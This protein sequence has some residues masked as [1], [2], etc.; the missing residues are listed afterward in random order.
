MNS[1]NDFEE[2]LK[3]LEARYGSFS[4][5]VRKADIVYLGSDSGR[6]CIGKRLP[7]TTQLKFPD[8][9]NVAYYALQILV[10]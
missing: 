8:R 3:I 7:R 6:M 10:M 4:C 9:H 5:Q 1:V 2:K